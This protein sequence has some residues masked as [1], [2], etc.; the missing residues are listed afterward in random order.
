MRQIRK[1]AGLTDDLRRQIRTLEAICSAD[2]SLYMKLNWDMLETRPDNEINDLLCYD[3]TELVAFLGLYCMGTDFAE[4][5]ITGMVHPEFRRQGIFKA[6]YG[7]AQEICKARGAQRIL[8]VS[9][10][11]SEAGRRFAED[12]GLAYSFS[13]Y[14]MRCDAYKPPASLPERFA[15]RPAGPADLPLI[16]HI[17]AV[18]FEST[19]SFDYGE[20]LKY[21]YIADLDGIPVGTIGLDYEGPLGYVFGVAI[22][23][24][25]RGHGYGRAMLDAVL[26]IHFEKA[27]AGVILE[28]A[29][30]ND[31]ALSLYRSV[32]FNTVTVYDYHEILL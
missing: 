16:E 30:K 32:G 7:E 4:V 29:V 22:L 17:N 28:V 10:R 21:S 11:R 8:L 27:T 18:R 9:E 19:V 1:S 20:R 12:A 14:R 26:K 15:L 13:E 3:E 25:F 2:E 6:L 5:E 24:E 23:P 31:T